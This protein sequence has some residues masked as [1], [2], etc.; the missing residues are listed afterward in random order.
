MFGY[1]FV[2]GRG[3]LALCGRA[4]PTELIAFL[5][6]EGFGHFEGITTRDVGSFVGMRFLVGEAERLDLMGKLTAFARDGYIGV[7]AARNGKT[8]ADASLTLA[9]QTGRN[10]NARCEIYC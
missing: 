7:A 3:R 5:Q 10:G 1:G 6:I 4:T 9:S 8:P 2:L